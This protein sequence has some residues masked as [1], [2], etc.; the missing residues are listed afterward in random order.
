M[1]VLLTGASG[2]IALHIIDVL[3]SKNHK[4]IGTVRS[5]SKADKITKQF[6]ELYPQGELSFE[7]VEDI[8]AP[9]A[10]NHVLQKHPEIKKV[11]HTASPFSFGLNKDLKDAYLT[12]ATEGTKNILIA[13]KDYA[14]QVDKVVVTS[15]F[16]SIYDGNN[17][18]KRDF[19]HKEETWN[20]IVWSDVQNEVDAYFA[21]KKLAEELART[22]VKENNVNF[23]LTTINPPYVLGPQKFDD[24]LVNPTLNTS[25][26]IVNS[27]LS[28]KLDEK[29]FVQGFSGLAVDV[30]DVSK[31]HVQAIEDN[32]LDDKRIFPVNGAFVGQTILNII[33]KQFPEL[34]N[35]IGKGDDDEAKN[36][37]VLKD[38]AP[39]YDNSKTHEWTGLKEI[40]FEQTIKDSVQQIL[41]FQKKNQA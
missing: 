1:S 35:K 29:E 36:E 5:Q 22:F 3:L 25:A 38:H 12:P 23:A 34:N 37:Q 19:I 18:H 10:F 6:K 17:A 27:L 31:L 8:A 30:R 15:S 9:G 21:S 11:L 20:P 14:P 26:E 32:K 13:I 4:V 2:F 33:H 41:D 16:A 39:L 7:I 24:V 40:S 28:T